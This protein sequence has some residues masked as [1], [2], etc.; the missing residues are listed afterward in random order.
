MTWLVVVSVAVVSLTVVLFVARY[1]HQEVV[2]DWAGVLSPEAARIVAAVEADAAMDEHMMTDA[3]ARAM[4]AHERAELQEAVRLLELAFWVVEDATPGR[5]QRLRS[6]A[7]I[8][9]QAAAVLP[10]PPVRP[11]T[12]RLRTVRT[13]AGL[14]ALLHAILVTPAERLAMRARVLVATFRLLVW[15]MRRAKTVAARRPEP[16]TAWKRFDAAL[17][18]WKAADREHLESYRAAM[19]TLSDFLRREVPVS[20]G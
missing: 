19:M 9:R 16:G 4:A 14:G 11:S 18:D 8:C 13:L 15:T 2:K 10:L 7:A 12:Y 5:L 17:A 1:R 20:L 6:M 3:W